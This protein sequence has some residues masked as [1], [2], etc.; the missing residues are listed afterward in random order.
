MDKLI[1]EQS[2]VKCPFTII[3]HKTFHSGLYLEM[4]ANQ[5]HG[6]PIVL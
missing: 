6:E 1:V 5:F 4:S 3:S 2:N